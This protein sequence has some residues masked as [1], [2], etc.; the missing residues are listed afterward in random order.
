VRDGRACPITHHHTGIPVITYPPHTSTMPVRCQ[1]LNA[2]AL[3]RALADVSESLPFA[4]PHFQASGETVDLLDHWNH[5]FTGGPS[6]EINYSARFIGR[7]EAIKIPLAVAYKRH[8]G[9]PLMFVTQAELDSAHL[10]DSV[11]NLVEAHP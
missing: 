6:V 1:P 8:G 2:P 10:L 5:R 4:S 11:A 9:D 7:I 3:L